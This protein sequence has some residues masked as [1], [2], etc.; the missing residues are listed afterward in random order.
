MSLERAQIAKALKAAKP[1]L[2]LVNSESDGRR[3]TVKRHTFICHAIED[4]EERGKITHDQYRVATA[5]IERR[6]GPG[7]STVED[8]LVTTLGVRA[9]QAA[10]LQDPDCIQKYRHRWVDALIAE[11]SK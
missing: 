11:F 8:F 4:A 3:I 6:L 5:M 7:H 10:R 2:R 9:Y 1:Y